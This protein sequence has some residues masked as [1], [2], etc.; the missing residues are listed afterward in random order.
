LL[1]RKSQILCLSDFMLSCSISRP[2]PSPF[3]ASKLPDSV[4]R[5]QVIDRIGVLRCA[6]HL[7]QFAVI[8]P[9]VALLRSNV[10]KCVVI[11]DT[12][13]Y[14]SFLNIICCTLLHCINT[15]HSPTDSPGIWGNPQE[16]PEFRGNATG[17][18]LESGGFLG[19]PGEFDGF[20]AEFTFFWHI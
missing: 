6:L 14:F 19:I 7:N 15:F 20:R 2:F 5:C 11:F 10:S 13:A 18:P 17:I 3:Q 1:F 12:C 8:Y 16:F 4:N 9:H